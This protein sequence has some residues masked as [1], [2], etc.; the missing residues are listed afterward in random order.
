LAIKVEILGEYW[1]ALPL[2]NSR[3]KGEA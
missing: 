3:L 2:R 1:I